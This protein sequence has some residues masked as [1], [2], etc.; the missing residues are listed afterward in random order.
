MPEWQN[1]NENEVED[2]ASADEPQLTFEEDF[3]D[4]QSAQP[5][6]PPRN[7]VEKDVHPGRH[8][9][10]LVDVPHTV[11]PYP[12]EQEEKDEDSDSGDE[13]VFQLEPVDL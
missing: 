10:L 7:S 2:S 6:A 8:G 12:H 3:A 13:P 9:E 4:V 11:E 5:E 1:S